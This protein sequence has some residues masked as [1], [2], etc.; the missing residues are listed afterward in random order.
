[1]KLLKAGLTLAVALLAVNEQTA[2][3]ATAT[4]TFQV[5][6]TVNSAF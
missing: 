6:A 3:A 2:Q 1:M 4:N 5:T